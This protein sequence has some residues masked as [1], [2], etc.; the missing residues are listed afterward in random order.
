M[1]VYQAP[2]VKDR[3]ATGDDL[4]TITDSGGKKKLTPSP[5]T[6]EEPGTEI[7][8]AL[9]M[10]LMKAVEGLDVNI[11]PY[12]DYWWRRRA[13]S[14]AYAETQSSAFVSGNAG[15]G[16]SIIY[17]FYHGENESYPSSVTFKIASSITIN[18]STGAVTMNSPTTKTVKRSDYSSEYAMAEALQSMCAGKYISGLPC[19]QDATKVM[20]VPQVAYVKVYSVASSTTAPTRGYIGFLSPTGNWGGWGPGTDVQLI[21]SIKQTTTGDWEY[22]S[23]PD[24]TAY[25]HSGTSGGYEYVYYG[26]IYSYVLNPPE[27]NSLALKTVNITS[28]SYSS[29]KYSVDVPGNICLF[30]LA[31]SRSSAI[32]VIDKSS[33]EIWYVINIIRYGNAGTVALVRTDKYS[34]VTSE[35]KYNSYPEYICATYSAG[36]LLFGYGNT[37]DSEQ[38]NFVGTVYLLPLK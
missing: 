14:G 12:T 26:Q 5:T 1:A 23:S 15:Y 36:K 33:G 32:G 20:K 8:R 28:A 24:S 21:G 7:N 6:I 13:S 18:Q 10:P 27:D 37:G 22:L 11:L 30:A 35:D 25:P 31:A 38:F 9:L 3:V 19:Q 29:N 34:I 4:Y 16:N 17:F 2:D